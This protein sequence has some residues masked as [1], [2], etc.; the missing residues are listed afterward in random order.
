MIAGS[1]VLGIFT[2]GI[3]LHFSDVHKPT[4]QPVMMVI[5]PSH[6]QQEDPTIDIL[7]RNANIPVLWRLERKDLSEKNKNKSQF[8]QN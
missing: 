7:I 6:S 4:V 3:I 8:D 2:I 1:G 5:Q